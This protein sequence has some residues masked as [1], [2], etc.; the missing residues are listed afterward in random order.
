[1]TK[2][3][4]TWKIT[5]EA[6]SPRPDDDLILEFVDASELIGEPVLNETFIDHIVQHAKTHDTYSIFRNV[7]EIVS[8]SGE[9]LTGRAI[10][11]LLGITSED[12]EKIGF[13]LGS[14]QKGGYHVIGFWPEEFATK[15]QEDETIWRD[16]IQQF[17]ADPSFWR[18][19]DLIIGYE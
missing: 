8:D 12:D 18:Q 9:D 14:L 1:M 2:I 10:W 19:V 5:F 6:T 13:L 4:N 11:A 17:G 15:I 7:K 16:K 3:T